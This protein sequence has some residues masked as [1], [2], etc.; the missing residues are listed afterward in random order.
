MLTAAERSCRRCGSRPR[1]AAQS[2]G[3][4]GRREARSKRGRS[5]AKSREPWVSDLSGAARPHRVMLPFSRM[6]ARDRGC[7]GCSLAD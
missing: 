4:E 3:A 5:L 1:K 6:S 2:A 7:R